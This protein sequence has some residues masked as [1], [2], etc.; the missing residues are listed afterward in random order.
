MDYRLA[1]Q[2]PFPRGLEDSHDALRWAA[3]NASLLS[4]DPTKGFLLG[5]VSAGANFGGALAYLARDERLNPPITGLL[6]S[7]PCC[8]MPQ[9]FDLVPQ[10][11]DEL[12]SLEQNRNADLLDVRSYCQL[13]EGGLL[14]GCFQS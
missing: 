1:P 13:V 8:L 6:L 10:W 3:Q 2:Y 5:G 12:F 9:A 7:I 4:A 11:R 14:Y